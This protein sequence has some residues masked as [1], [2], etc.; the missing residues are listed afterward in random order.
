MDKN[1]LIRV[2][3]DDEAL[4]N[5]IKFSLELDG[6][7]VAAYNSA[8]SFLEQ[9]D[10]EKPGCIVL[11]YQMP[12]LNGIEVQRLLVEQEIILPII[13]LTAHA[14]V[15]MVIGAFK[16]GAFDFLRKPV[17]PESLIQTILKTIKKNEERLEEL[18]QSTPETRYGQLSEQQR[19]VAR[20]VARNLTCAVIGERLGKS[21]RTIER[22]RANVLHLLGVGNPSELKSFLLKISKY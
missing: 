17:Q 2:V 6:L 15:D 18:R 20:L 11:D 16:G 19:Q 12:G 3:D 22:H 4:L 5:A 9:D 1:S 13:F 21:K 7:N 8:E 14:D 10:L